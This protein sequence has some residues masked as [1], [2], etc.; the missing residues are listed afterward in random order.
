MCVQSKHCST[1]WHFRPRIRLNPCPVMLST[2]QVTIMLWELWPVRVL[3]IL[4]PPKILIKRETSNFLGKRISKSLKPIYLFLICRQYTEIKS[5]QSYVV[6][7][8]PVIVMCFLQDGVVLRL[9]LIEIWVF[10]KVEH[11]LRLHLNKIS[12]KSTS[13]LYNGFD[14]E[15]ILQKDFSQNKFSCF[16]AN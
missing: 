2:V 15:V 14:S 1:K 10:L 6:L 9:S 5:K 13:I 11:N 4:F 7:I 3:H 12:R 16:P 8:N